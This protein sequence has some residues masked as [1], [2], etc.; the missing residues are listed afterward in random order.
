MALFDNIRKAV[1]DTT[2]TVMGDVM[3]WT[4]SLG[5]IEYSEKVHFKNPQGED[6]LGTLPEG[7]ELEPV[8]TTAE[9]REE[10]F[11]G[12]YDLVR[13]SGA[14]TEVVTIKGQDYFV[15]SVHKTHDGA[16]YV[17]TLE[18]TQ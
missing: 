1:H 9:Y 13:A 5:G 7:F 17:I 16:T 14:I 10:Q 11:P 15:T 6:R 4:D 2:T 12:L 3:L 8:E 18:A